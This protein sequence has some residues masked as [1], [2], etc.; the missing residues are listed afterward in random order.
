MYVP[1]YVRLKNVVVHTSPLNNTLDDVRSF[2]NC[3]R[4]ALKYVHRYF[5]RLGDSKSFTRFVPGTKA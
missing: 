1:R 2:F 4:I 3:A 5:M